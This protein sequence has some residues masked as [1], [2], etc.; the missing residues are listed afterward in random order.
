VKSLV[1]TQYIASMVSRQMGVI[2]VCV[3]VFVRRFGGIIHVDTN[4][5]SDGRLEKLFVKGM[6]LNSQILYMHLSVH[7][8]ASMISCQAGD[9]CAC[10]LFLSD[11]LEELFMLARTRHLTQG[12]KNYLSK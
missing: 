7:Y 1:I 4:S 6:I 3:A 12:W 9:C 11:V 8:I 5:S 2:A 10:L